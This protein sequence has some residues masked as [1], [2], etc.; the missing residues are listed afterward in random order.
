MTK[1]A[2]TRQAILRH[3]VEAAYRLG[4]GGLTIGHLAA[5]TGMS[6]SGL[7]AHFR[8]KELLQV[9]VLRQA[10]ADFIDSVIRPA[11]AAPRGEPRVRELFERWVVC[12]KTRQPGGCLFVKAATELDE[13][14]GPVRDQLVRD[15]RDLYDSIARMF[16]TGIAEGHFRADADP[17]QFAAD[18]D[19]VM[20][21]YYHAHRLLE[22]ELAETRARR[23]FEALIDAARADDDTPAAPD[24]ISAIP[25]H[26]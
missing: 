24:R 18:L 7:F 12:G 13:Q 21:A 4:L 5:A 14:D 22:D 9:E 26:P 6:K 10:R 23:A 20:L 11:V 2:E 3:G 17:V 8:S 19:G 25:A 1:G 16:G 15:H